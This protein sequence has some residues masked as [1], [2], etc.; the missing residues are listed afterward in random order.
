MGVCVWG[1]EDGT[2]SGSQTDRATMS[3]VDA[4]SV[5]AGGLTARGG[6]AT[7][8]GPPGTP[9]VAPVRVGEATT[10]IGAGG[11]GG[12]GGGGASDAGRPGVPTDR[13]A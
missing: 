4:G 3:D 5:A 6:T 7:N 8:A 1:G 9:A 10:G 12:G 2:A 11:G 13:A